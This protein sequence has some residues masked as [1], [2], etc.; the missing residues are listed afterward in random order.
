MT[1]AAAQK[2]LALYF[3]SLTAIL[4]TYILVFPETNFLPI[5][6][7]EARAAFQIII[8]VLL[9]QLTVIFQWIGQAGNQTKSELS[10]IPS[11]AIK[12]PALAALAVVLIIIVS[13]IALN[14]GDSAKQHDAMFSNGITFAVAII[15][16]STVYLVARLFPQS[17]SSSGGQNLPS[18]QGEQESLKDNP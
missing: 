9:G 17:K 5:D 16:V 12:A 15:N 14:A 4:G 6:R 8:P 18:L 2:W 11:W 10:P 13:L 7:E 1:K 3:L